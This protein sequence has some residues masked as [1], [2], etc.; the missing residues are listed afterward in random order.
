MLYNLEQ[1][2]INDADETMIPDNAVLFINAKRGFNLRNIYDELVDEYEYEFG[3]HPCSGTIAATNKSKLYDV[4]DD[5]K[6]SRKHIEDYIKEKKIECEREACYGIC[7][8]PPTIRKLKTR[9]QVYHYYKDNPGRRKWATMYEVRGLGNVIIKLESTNKEALKVA[10]E[11]TEKTSFN[12][13]VNIV[14]RLVDG[15]SECI[16]STRYKTSAMEKTGE[17]VLFG[18]VPPRYTIDE[19]NIVIPV[20]EPRDEYDEIGWNYFLGIW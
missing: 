12:A 8:I 6:K 9:S 17:W 2:D 14:K 15:S 18:W 20:I 1:E 3:H 19:N 13:E 11:Y 7:V 4:T 10:K 5:F 16:A